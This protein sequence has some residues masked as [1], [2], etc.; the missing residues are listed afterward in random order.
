MIHTK[1]SEADIE[2]ARRR[3]SEMG[4]LAASRQKGAGNVAGFLGEACVLRECGG[5]LV[6]NF[7]FDVTIGDLKIDVKTKSC[8]SQPRAHYNCSVMSYQLRNECDGYIFTRVNLSSNDV[9]ILGY[10][11]K[12]RLIE[13]GI[14]F[15]KG[16]TDDG[17]TVKE[18]CV[19]IQIF[20]L[21]ELPTQRIEF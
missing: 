18:D 11:A 12:A 2:E 8:T 13:E 3:S 19:S 21:D 17:F 15:A 5:T 20:E 10:I 14:R 1:V 9:W 7:N 16:D 6:D 4:I